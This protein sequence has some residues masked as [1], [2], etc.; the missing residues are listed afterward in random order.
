[1]R[2]CIEIILLILA[3]FVG[4]CVKVCAEDIDGKTISYER[5]GNQQI[6]RFVLD[7]TTGSIT[8]EQQKSDNE[9]LFEAVKILADKIPSP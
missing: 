5:F 6:G 2:N 9:T 3:L 7:P 8:L 1:M 4:G